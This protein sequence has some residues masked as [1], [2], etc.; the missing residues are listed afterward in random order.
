M[1]NWSLSSLS[2]VGLSFSHP[3]SLDSNGGHWNRKTGE[4]HFHEGL[5]TDS[6]SNNSSKYEYEPFTPPYTPPTNN[7]YRSA[8]QVEEDDKADSS[9]ANTIASTVVIVFL[10]LPFSISLIKYLILLIYE[11]YLHKFF[12]KYNIEKFRQS[13]HDFIAYRDNIYECENVC[14][15]IEKDL[16]TPDEYEI[17]TDNLPKEKGANGWGKTFTVYRTM[18]G[19]KIHIK[20]GCCGAKIKLNIYSFRNATNI[21]SLLCRK[22]S[23]KYILPNMNWCGE[24]LHFLDL[25]KQYDARYKNFS[26]LYLDIYYYYKKCNSKYFS[27][28]LLFYPQNKNKLDDLNAEFKKISIAFKN[29]LKRE[30]EIL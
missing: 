7:P 10:F 6:N 14:R 15:T 5:N 3:G 8:K 11:E 25:K 28:I 2:I 16:K 17:G 24:Y 22:C 4:Y 27:F 23:N 18:S 13:L 21:S 30:K 29:Y 19:S 26:K 1:V 12:P 9:A 20:C